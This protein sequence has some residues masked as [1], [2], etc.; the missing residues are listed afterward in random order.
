[1]NEATIERE[2]ERLR[3]E[4]ADRLVADGAVTSPAWEAAFAEVPRHVFVPVFYRQTPSEQPAVDASTPGEWL[5]SVYSDQLLVV[6]PDV[7]A[8]STAPSLM[9]EMLEALDPAGHH[10]VLEIGTGTGYNAGLLSHRLGDR[11]VVSV[12]IAADLVNDAKYRLAS[13]GYQP[14][15]VVG[16]GADGWPGKAPYDSIIA[17]CAPDAVPAAWLDQVRP[18]GRIVAPIATGV[19]VIDIANGRKAEGRFLPGGA[20]FMALRATPGQVDL[21]TQI[22]DIT[23]AVVPERA[24]ELGEAIWFDND[25]QFVSSAALPGMRFLTKLAESGTTIF[26]HADG[27]WAR[28]DNGRVAQGGPQRLWD[29]LESAHRQWEELDRPMRD[30]F[31]ITVDGDDQYIRLDGGGVVWPLRR[32]NA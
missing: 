18:G 31:S 30:R 23:S 5:E 6:S 11:N 26:T 4:F 20:Y 32:V 16:D 9:A 8:S 19:A 29:A 1:M 10:K 22:A 13:I 27:S 17:T 24:T 7:K 21:G 3:R 2:A 28:L 25:F 14:T 15:L 12:D